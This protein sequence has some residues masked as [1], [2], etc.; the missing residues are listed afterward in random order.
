M[1]EGSLGDVR[2]HGCKILEYWLCS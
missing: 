1:A 2:W